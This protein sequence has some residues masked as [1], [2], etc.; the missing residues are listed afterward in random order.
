[1]QQGITLTRVNIVNTLETNDLRDRIYL[2]L[3]LLSGIPVAVPLPSSVG[4][5]G[6]LA[7]NE[8]RGDLL[9]AL[10]EPGQVGLE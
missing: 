4:L 10:Q 8:V 2:T 7:R 6:L 1:M 3:S 5:P 9:C